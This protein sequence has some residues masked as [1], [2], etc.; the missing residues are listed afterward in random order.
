M[1]NLSSGR[2]GI[3][4]ARLGEK[5][6]MGEIGDR[7]Y[8]DPKPISGNEDVTTATRVV[9]TVEAAGPTINV[10]NA[11][12]RPAQVAG[13]HYV[14]FL[15]DLPSA[16]AEKKE[17][18]GQHLESHMPRTGNRLHTQV[19]LGK[20]LNYFRRLQEQLEKYYTGQFVKVDLDTGDHDVGPSRL[21]VVANYNARY[22]DR[23]G[24][25]WNASLWI[26][27]PNRQIEVGTST[28]SGA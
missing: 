17:I 27:H 10:E 7:K 2:P 25:L 24:L 8:V 1:Q 22:G 23:R 28:P 19:D 9:T 15:Q 11:L 21:G 13:G 3:F 26:D 18:T 16:V 14:E 6:V 5:T 20:G 4:T 12:P